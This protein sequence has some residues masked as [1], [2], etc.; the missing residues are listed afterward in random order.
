MIL[1]CYRDICLYIYIKYNIYI[2][3]YISLREERVDLRSGLEPELPL[4]ACLVA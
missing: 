4:A 3:I 2:H 1:Q